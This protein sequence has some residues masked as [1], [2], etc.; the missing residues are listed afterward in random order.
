MRTVSLIL[1]IGVLSIFAAKASELIKYK[2]A[3]SLTFEKRINTIHSRVVD[4][5]DI[6]ALHQIKEFDEVYLTPLK[7]EG[8]V[9]K[10]LRKPESFENKII[11][12]C[13]MTK[14]PLDEYIKILNSYFILYNKNKINEQLLNRCIFNEFDTD[15]IIAKQYKNPSVRLLLNKMLNC[16]TL[17]NEFKINVK[18]TLNGKWYNDLKRTKRL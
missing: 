9:I 11:A 10:Y 5:T 1:I 8:A 14:L 15:Y 13:S 16:K 6:F 2:Y 17:S 12:I 7:F 4:L 3:D 18:E